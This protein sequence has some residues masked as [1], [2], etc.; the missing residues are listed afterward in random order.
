LSG[1]PDERHTEGI[2]MATPI[3]NKHNN[4]LITLFF[5]KNSKEIR[6]QQKNITGDSLI[7]LLIISE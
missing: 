7:N 6:M 2:A 4:R 1:I 5:I 3:R